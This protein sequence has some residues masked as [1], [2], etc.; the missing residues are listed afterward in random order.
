M[1]PWSPARTRKELEDLRGRFAIKTINR[2]A[3]TGDFATIDLVATI[4]GEQVDSTSDVSYEVRL[5]TMLDGQD[6][7]L[8]GTKAGDR[9]PSRPRSRARRPRSEEAENHHHGQ[10]YEGARA[11]QADDDFAQMC[12]IGSTIST[13]SG[14]PQEAGRRVKVPTGPRHARRPDRRSPRRVEI[15]LPESAV[16]HQVEHRVGGH[17]SPRKEAREAVEGDTELLSEALA[18][19]DVR[20]PSRSSSTRSRCRRTSASTS[21]S[22]LFPS[23]VEHVVADLGRSKAAIEAL[24]VVTVKDTNGADVDLSKFFDTDPATERRARR[25]P[26][27]RVS[28]GCE[29]CAANHPRSE[30]GPQTR[31]TRTHV[32]DGETASPARALRA[33]TLRLTQ[34]GHLGPQAD[35]EVRV[36][37][38]NTRLPA[39]LAAGTGRSVYQRLLKGRIIWLGGEVLMRTRTRSARSCCCSRPRIG[40]RRLRLLNSPG[41]SVT[42]GIT[43]Y[44]TI[45]IKP[46]VVTVGRAGSASI[47]RSLLTAGARQALHHASHARAATPAPGWRWR[48]GDRIRI[49]AD[50]IL[51]I[52]EGTRGDHRVSLQ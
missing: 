6:T 16:D 7:A 32:A 36:S 43:I 50:L 35:E 25:S 38:R 33:R 40:P 44:D 34:W 15:V 5:G 24:K 39:W 19:F 51:G 26:T 27:S 42:A 31:P 49:N 14:R 37:V 2:K 4:N 8:R 46:D 52:E 29:T 41:G 22:V 30:G 28:A 10:G 20:F 23:S 1:P 3:K 45:H 11:A 48:F 47:G 9:S 21:T 18:K 12:S 17:L 13:N